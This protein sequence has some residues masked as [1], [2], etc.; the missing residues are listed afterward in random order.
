[1]KHQN[2]GELIKRL[3]Y[4]RKH[5]QP[6]RNLPNLVQ[7][8]GASANQRPQ[9][10]PASC[11]PSM[12]AATEQLRALLPLSIDSANP[13]TPPKQLCLS[14][15]CRN[16]K[17]SRRPRN[18]PARNMPATGYPIDRY[19]SWPVRG[20]AILHLVG[21]SRTLRNPIALQESRFWILP[22][23]PV[24]LRVPATLTIYLPDLNCIH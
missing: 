22:C 2:T 5:S 7:H 23:S 9:R 21:R 18:M 10:Q 14:H 19:A 4:Q 6:S 11:L 17:H 20:R 1:M 16:R 24:L 12:S 13:P 15:I 8:A 3:A